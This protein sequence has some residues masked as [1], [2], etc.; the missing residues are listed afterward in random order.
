[1]EGRQVIGKLLRFQKNP[2]CPFHMYIT[3][4]SPFVCQCVS[5]ANEW[6]AQRVKP[7]LWQLCILRGSGTKL[8]FLF[9]LLHCIEEEG[10]STVY[11]EGTRNFD[12]PQSSCCTTHSPEMF[13]KSRRS[14]RKWKSWITGHIFSSLATWSLRE[15]KNPPK[16]LFL[17][18]TT[19]GLK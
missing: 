19:V 17:F 2:T 11:S 7:L 14:S 5:G 3:V 12:W 13:D 16:V 9:F 18:V 4:A 10:I 6:A 1:M 8:F 15:K